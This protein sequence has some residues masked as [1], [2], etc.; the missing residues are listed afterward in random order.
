MK[1]KRFV[2][3]LDR[4]ADR[5]GEFWER[6][7]G[8]DVERFSAFDGRAFVDSGGSHVLLSSFRNSV[9]SG[10]FGCWMSH[11]S[12]WRLLANSSDVDAF[13]IFEDDVFFSDRFFTEFD[14]LL[15]ELSF[16][17]FDLFYFG[18][19]FKRDFSPRDM[20]GWEGVGKFFKRKKNVK[21]SGSDFDRGTFGY[22]LSHA[23]AVKLVELFES[24]IKNKVK[25]QPVDGWLNG[26]RLNSLESFDV[27][28]HLVY[29]PIGYK[30]D[31]Q[32]VR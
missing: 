22:V 11:L 17:N 30:T 24:D 29:S 27:F 15:G 4:R 2:I 21:M 23:G 1:F 9:S 6:Y 19:R 7:R 8:V 32:R 14:G 5:L 20:S 13:I 28:P 25:F 10:V 12:L 26:H 16:I 31:I 3:N 18:G